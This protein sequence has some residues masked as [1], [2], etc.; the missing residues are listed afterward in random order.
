MYAIPENTVI[1]INQSM[2]FKSLLYMLLSIDIEV[3]VFKTGN[4][5]VIA[6]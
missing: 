1:G 4:R 6:K 3:Y 2:I 5:K